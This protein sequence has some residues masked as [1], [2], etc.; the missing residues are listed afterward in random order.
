MCL[1]DAALGR[2]SL[3]GGGHD[4]AGHTEW[5]DSPLPIMATPTD[6]LLAWGVYSGI[7]ANYDLCDCARGEVGVSAVNP[8]HAEW[9]S[10][11]S[12]GTW[13]GPTVMNQDQSLGS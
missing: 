12:T 7:N 13:E 2:I 4:S 1:P 8:R 6:I 10:S 5:R 9:G 3:V 11:S